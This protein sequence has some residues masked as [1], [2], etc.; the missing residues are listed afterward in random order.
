MNDEWWWEWWPNDIRG[1]WGARASRHLSYRWGKT[2]NK[3]SPRKLVPTGDR[4]R[5]RCLTGAHAAA[6]PTAV[7]PYHKIFSKITCTVQYLQFPNLK[8]RTIMFYKLKN[9]LS[10]LD[11]YTKSCITLMFKSSSSSSGEFSDQGQVFHCKLRHQGCSSVQ[12]QVFHCKLKNQ[13]CSFTRDK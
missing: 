13:G 10:Y 1:P 4:T 5:T 9:N 7:D 3:T 2:P 11:I 6:T 8:L 12:R